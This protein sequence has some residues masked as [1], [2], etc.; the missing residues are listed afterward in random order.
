MSES[1]RS[2]HPSVWRDLDAPNPIKFMIPNLCSVLGVIPFYSDVKR[3]DLLVTFWV[4]EVNWDFRLIGI[5]ASLYPSPKGSSLQREGSTL[6]TESCGKLD[7]F[8][9]KPELTFKSQNLILGQM[10][11]AFAS[12]KSPDVFLF[13]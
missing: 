6:S 7:T 3:L 12:K 4:K 10:S 8:C 2:T 5:H 1:P 11:L 13:T 9:G